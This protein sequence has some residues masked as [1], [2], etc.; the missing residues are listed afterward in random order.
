MAVGIHT[1]H[2]V[3]NRE[4]LYRLGYVQKLESNILTKF[5]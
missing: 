4:Y 5:V 2:V 1:V 3:D